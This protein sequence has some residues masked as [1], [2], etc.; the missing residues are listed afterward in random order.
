MAQLTDIQN[1]AVRQEIEEYVEAEDERPA[2]SCIVGVVC[3]AVFGDD[4][5]MLQ[6]LRVGARRPDS[7]AGAPSRSAELFVGG[8]EI[9]VTAR[10]CTAIEDH[11]RPGIDLAGAGDRCG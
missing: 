2:A 7:A 10:R 5:D 1:E 3:I 9:S 8:P 6:R 11:R 4:Q